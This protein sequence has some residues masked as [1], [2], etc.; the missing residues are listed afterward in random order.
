LT[1]EYSVDDGNN[2]Q[3]YHK[4]TSVKAKQVLIRSRSNDGKRT[5]RIEKVQ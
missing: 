1:I 2:W 5:S 3:I 4:P